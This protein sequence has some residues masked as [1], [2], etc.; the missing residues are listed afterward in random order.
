[1]SKAHNKRKG[2]ITLNAITMRYV[3]LALLLLLLTGMAG[4]FH[5]AYSVL[6]EEATE[7]ANKQAELQS[8][9]NRLRKLEK[10]KQDL[11]KYKP[12]AERA[13]Q[14]AASAKSYQYQNQVIDDLKFYAATAGVDID[15]FTFKEDDSKAKTTPT[16]PAGAST[17]GAPSA[18]TAPSTGGAPNAAGAAPKS[19][20]VSIQLGKDV[21]YTNL[22]HF[23]HLI[24]KNLTRMQIAD[25]SL[26]RGENNASVSVQT[27]TL[28]VYIR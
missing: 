21:G 2:G 18:P 13:A 16:K 22:L 9:D 24:E 4:G 10:L 27:L 1:M 15:S 12:S 19:T 28:E 26:G 11:A 3:L 14:I 20:Q 23:L 7:S 8:I 5:F 25:L 17:P 6:H